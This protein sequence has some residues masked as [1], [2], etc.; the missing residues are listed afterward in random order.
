VN[1]YSLGVLL[2]TLKDENVPAGTIR[3]A[4]RVASVAAATAIGTAQERIPLALRAAVPG[5]AELS[6]DQSP[7]SDP[8]SEAS[9]HGG[10]RSQAATRPA[11]PGI[12][13]ARVAAVDV[14]A[15]GAP[16]TTG[17]A[18]ESVSIDISPTAV[19]IGEA[20]REEPQKSTPTVR[21]S[22]PLV[23]RRDI[24]PQPLAAALQSSIEQ[25]GLFYESHL[26][27]WALQQYPQSAL[28]REPQATA[29]QDV[30]A[31]ANVV[32]DATRNDEVSSA[33]AHEPA[34]PLFRQQLEVLE[35]RQ[36][37]WA[38]EIWPGQEADIHIRE[39]DVRDP[40][41]T[42]AAWRT[43]VMLDLPELG[44][45]ELSLTLQSNALRVQL[46]ASDA[47]RAAVLHAGTPVLRQA[48]AGQAFA[49]TGLDISHEANS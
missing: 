23:A 38:G 29:A 37:A 17:L 49:V 24:A 36:L 4:V 42:Q 39:D 45:V 32:V 7:E 6:G 41:V 5:V 11:A 18:P 33:I 15:R 47:A 16:A 8:D 22:A 30:A 27:R 14:T 2:Q 20:L 3:P 10:S 19:L 43:S 48:L 31:A 28:A 13:A 21:A 35:S 9:E 46:Q 40:A 26:Q 34:P 1:V 44:H 25:S 12:A